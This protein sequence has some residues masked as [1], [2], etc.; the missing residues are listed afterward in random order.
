MLR[1]DRLGSS[2]AAPSPCDKPAV[3]LRGWDRCLYAL[4]WCLG[5]LVLSLSFYLRPEAAGVG[6][7]TQLGLPPCGVYELFGKPCPS[8]GMT[9]AFALLARGL[10]S[11]AV[12]VQP[13]GAAVFAAA[14]WL[15]LYIP[16]AFLKRRPFDHIFELKPLLVTAVALIVL[17]LA[18]WIWRLV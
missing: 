2:E 8:C 7:H 3:R 16:I 9:T 11:E 13:A 4:C 15:W 12:K 14:V 18:V 17:I 1:H 10:I 5:A 6:T